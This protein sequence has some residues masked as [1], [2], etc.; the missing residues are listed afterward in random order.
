MGA[1]VYA[2]C[3]CEGCRAKEREGKPRNGEADISRAGECAGGLVGGQGLRAPPPEGAQVLPL[4]RQGALSFH[5]L[6]EGPPSP[7]ERDESRTAPRHPRSGADLRPGATRYPVPRCC[8]GHQPCQRKMRPRA[9]QNRYARRA[10]RRSNFFCAGPFLGRTDLNAPVT[11]SFR[12]R[13]KLGCGPGFHSA[14]IG[15][16]LSQPAPRA[17]RARSRAGRMCQPAKCSRGCDGAISER[18]RAPQVM[19][20]R[21]RSKAGRTVLGRIELNASAARW[22]CGER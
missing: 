17:A 20:E 15:R 8:G 11:R 2:G 12:E 19:S 10:E 16:N 9:A 21:S 1:D 5:Q 13:G 18:P 3:R 7:S 6:A 4:A 14:R 22:L